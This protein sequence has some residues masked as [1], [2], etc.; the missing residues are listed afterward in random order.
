MNLD[1]SLNNWYK[2]GKSN[3]VKINNH[4]ELFIDETIKNPNGMF[5]I[6]QPST[7]ALAT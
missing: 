1:L 3:V 7:V 5:T 2:S 6:I 4:D